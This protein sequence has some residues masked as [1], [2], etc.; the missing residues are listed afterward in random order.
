MRLGPRPRYSA[1]S[2]QQLTNI[3][4]THGA[5]YLPHVVLLTNMAK[6]KAGKRKVTQARAPRVPSFAFEPGEKSYPLPIKTGSG[7]YNSDGKCVV[8]LGSLP[9]AEGHLRGLGW[10]VTCKIQG[11]GSFLMGASTASTVSIV[12]PYV[13]YDFDDEVEH[14]GAPVGARV[15][16]VTLV[17][18]PGDRIVVVATVSLLYKLNF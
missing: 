14:D 17:G 6:S 13:H 4:P 8:N 5:T 18:P 11:E 12:T 1:P 16:P 7:T 3:Q 15:R 10:R 2:Y 9:P